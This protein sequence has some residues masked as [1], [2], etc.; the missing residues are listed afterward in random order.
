[1]GDGVGVDGGEAAGVAD[2]DSD[3]VGVDGAVSVAEAVIAGLCAVPHPRAVT[4][5]PTVIA[6]GHGRVRKDM[7]RR[8]FYQGRAGSIRPRPGFNYPSAV[9]RSTAQLPARIRI[10]G[11]QNCGLN[12]REILGNDLLSHPVAR[13]VPSALVGLTAVFGMGTGVSPPLWSPN[14][15]SLAKEESSLR[16]RA[17]RGLRIHHVRQTTNRAGDP[18]AADPR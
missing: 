3:A 1:M 8:G 16:L 15:S 9:L 7:G 4:A 18:Q 11:G 13:A 17:M 14:I 5:M 10:Q 2:A 12:R 6:S